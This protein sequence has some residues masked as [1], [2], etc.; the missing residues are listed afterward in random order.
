MGI[1]KAIG[2]AIDRIID[3]SP[4]VRDSPSKDRYLTLVAYGKRGDFKDVV[5][6]MRRVLVEVA[7][8]EM[9]DESINRSLAEPPSIISWAI[10]TACHDRFHVLSHGDHDVLCFMPDDCLDMHFK[11]TEYL[12]KCMKELSSTATFGAILEWGEGRPL[13][14]V[15]TTGE[16]TGDMPS[17]A[18][19]V[20][21]IKDEPRSFEISL[22]IPQ[23]KNAGPMGCSAGK[24]F[25]IGVSEPNTSGKAYDLLAEERRAFSKRMAV[26]GLESDMVCLSQGMVEVRGSVPQPLSP[27]GATPSI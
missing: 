5:G 15:E 11:V 27:E 7:G 4:D 17:V 1:G 26:I 2:R 16:A 3:P 21:W 23:G 13:E 14:I 10:A 12:S 6:S 18:L 20:S 24:V 9:T 19:G 8:I 22:P 25:F